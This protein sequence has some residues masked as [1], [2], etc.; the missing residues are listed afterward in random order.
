MP[1]EVISS[2]FFRNASRSSTCASVSTLWTT[3]DISDSILDFFF[4]AFLPIPGAGDLDAVRSADL[5][6]DADLSTDPF[7]FAPV[8]ICLFLDP[9]R[10]AG[11]SLESDPL[12]PCR[13]PLLG[14]GDAHAFMFLELIRVVPI[15]L[16]DRLMRRPRLSCSLDDSSSPRLDLGDGLLESVFVELFHATGNSNEFLRPQVCDRDNTRVLSFC[17]TTRP[18]ALRLRDGNVLD[19]ALPP[20]L[21]AGDV[22]VGLSCPR[23]KRRGSLSPALGV[24]V[25][26]LFAGEFD[27]MAATCSPAISGRSVASSLDSG[28]VASTALLPVSGV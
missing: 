15:E 16:R 18:V 24:G 14:A 12:D 11:T 3:M 23:S 6:L 27:G 5:C 10:S 25:L 9:F 20:M 7:R 22:D 19:S 4:E 17:S 1:A 28:F 8:S 21:D 13:S 2:I 26:D